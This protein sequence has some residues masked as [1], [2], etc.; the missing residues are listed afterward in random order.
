MTE[1]ELRAWFLDFHPRVLPDFLVAEA[2]GTSRAI[3]NVEM[4]RYVQAA[5]VVGKD[6]KRAAE[7]VEFLMGA[8]H[9]T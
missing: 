4:A 8:K 7:I 3:T 5:H 6:L 9:A 2:D 1:D